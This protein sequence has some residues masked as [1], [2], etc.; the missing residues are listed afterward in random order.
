MMPELP[1]AVMLEFDDDGNEKAL[2]RTTLSSAQNEFV[3]SRLPSYEENTFDHFSDPGSD[4][5]R[6]RAAPTYKVPAAKKTSN[7]IKPASRISSQAQRFLDAASDVEIG[8]E[9][10]TERSPR[11]N[12]S[13]ASSKKA[14]RAAGKSDSADP[15][16][17]WVTERDGPAGRMRRVFVDGQGR[18]LIGKE[19]YAVYKGLPRQAGRGQ[20]GAG[21]ASHAG[22]RGAGRSRGGKVSR[23]KAS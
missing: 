11:Q 17:H 7:K 5:P 22:Q 9:D 19:A 14:W 1:S 3:P 8:E 10:T 16:G 12:R 23:R 20:R 15:A 13:A 4:P 6:K 2:V 18:R 21:R